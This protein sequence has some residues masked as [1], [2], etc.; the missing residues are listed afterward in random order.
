VLQLSFLSRP[1]RP[2]MACRR[3]TSAVNP[4]RRSP[5]E[6]ITAAEAVPAGRALTVACAQPGVPA[7]GER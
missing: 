7:G 3:A 5:G 2:S 6:T 1:S 4:A